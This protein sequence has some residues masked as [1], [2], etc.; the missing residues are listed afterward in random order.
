MSNFQQYTLRGMP[1]IKA[2]VYKRKIFAIVGSV[3]ALHKG[4][5]IDEDEYEN[6]KKNKEAK[7]GVIF[8]QDEDHVFYVQDLTQ[9]ECLI[10]TVSEVTFNAE[11]I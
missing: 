11:H 2:I 10:N 5:V 4:G 9:A 6:A 1:G 8:R 7:F 3:S